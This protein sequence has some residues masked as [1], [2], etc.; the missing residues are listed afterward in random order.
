[1]AFLLLWYLLF[2]LMPRHQHS[3]CLIF[4]FRS[5]CCS[6]VF[7]YDYTPCPGRCSGVLSVFIV[8][9]KSSG[10][11]CVVLGWGVGGHIFICM[12]GCA[13]SYKI[14]SFLTD[15]SSA[16]ALSF[17]INFWI[18]LDEERRKKQGWSDWAFYMNKNKWYSSYSR[19]ETNLIDVIIP[20][21]WTTQT[22]QNSNIKRSC[23][24]V[25]TTVTQIG[26]TQCKTNLCYRLLELSLLGCCCS[27]PT[28]WWASLWTCA[29]A[30]FDGGTTI[31]G[32]VGKSF[33]VPL[34]MSKFDLT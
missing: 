30:L 19:S 18:F 2:L 7:S 33:C 22:F 32:R 3:A 4:T 14:Y 11:R 31:R 26:D 24:H 8:D 21:T 15:N 34:M 10:Q 13:L 25:I 16:S 12:I 20:E 23:I 5:R 28:C 9:S 29:C 27:D 1:M 17:P 6:A